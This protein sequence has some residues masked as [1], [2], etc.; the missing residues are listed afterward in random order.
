MS[1][2]NV[3]DIEVA[4]YGDARKRVFHLFFPPSEVLTL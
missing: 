2:R 3:G 1:K 4:Y